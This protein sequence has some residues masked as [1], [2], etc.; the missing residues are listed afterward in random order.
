A[1]S[2]KTC[3]KLAELRPIIV[4]KLAPFPFYFGAISENIMRQIE[5][6]LAQLCVRFWR[7]SLFVS[8][9]KNRAFRRGGA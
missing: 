9:A 4:S 6:N 7:H 3:R 2:A 1:V 8:G 5:K